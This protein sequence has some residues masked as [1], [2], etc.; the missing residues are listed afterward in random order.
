MHP[1]EQEITQ[2]LASIRPP[3]DI[4]DKVDIGYSF[5]NNTL[6]IQETRPYWRDPVRKID[7]PVAKAKYVKSKDIWKIYWQRAS[8]KWETYGPQPECSNLQ[9]F[10]RLLQNDPHGCF[11]G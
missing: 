8:G 7:I 4:R 5:K 1:F 9:T 6:T 2:F 11:W 10:F 3:A